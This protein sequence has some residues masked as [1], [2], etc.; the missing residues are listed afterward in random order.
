MRCK[1][2]GTLVLAFVLAGWTGTVHAQADDEKY[3]PGLKV[4]TKAPEFSLKDQEGETVTLK[5]LL[6]DGPIALVF[7]R[8]ANW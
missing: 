1:W 7:H 2:I 3:D 4:G 8:S 6:K 5:G